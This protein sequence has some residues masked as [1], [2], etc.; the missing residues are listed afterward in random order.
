MSN[1]FP[2]LFSNRG[3]VKSFFLFFLN[4]GVI[5]KKTRNLSSSSDNKI[6]YM[7]L[8]SMY[9]LEVMNAHNY[10]TLEK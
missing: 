1:Q 3:V 4:R 2:L 5:E 10:G 9:V 7:N 8:A 6:I